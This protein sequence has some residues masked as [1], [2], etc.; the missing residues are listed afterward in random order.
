M[1]IY[2]GTKTSAQIPYF[3][4]AKTGLSGLVSR[5][6]NKPELTA[7]LLF[8]AL[9]D[10]ASATV[11]LPFDMQKITEPV[12]TEVLGIMGDNPDKVKRF[13]GNQLFL[14]QSYNAN[15]TPAINSVRNEWDITI[16]SFPS[17]AKKILAFV[18]DLK[19]EAFQ[20]DKLEFAVQMRLHVI[21][22]AKANLGFVNRV[23]IHPDYNDISVFFP[24]G[25]YNS[26][27]EFTDFNTLVLLKGEYGLET[28]AWEKGDNKFAHITPQYYIS[29]LFN[30][31]QAVEPAYHYSMPTPKQIDSM[32]NNEYYLRPFFSL[33]INRQRQEKLL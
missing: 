14:I 25:L 11:E 3:R 7:D 29:G 23:Q 1:Y 2:D 18:R 33:S 4:R 30:N 22:K 12:V 32:K 5:D 20:Q 17:I 28:H 15:K 31:Y 13:D 8:T 21:N 10:K 26:K 27:G 24:T 16:S 9:R 6:K 19:I